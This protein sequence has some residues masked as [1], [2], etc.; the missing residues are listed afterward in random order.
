VEQVTVQKI[1]SLPKMDSFFSGGKADPYAVIEYQPHSQAGN[2]EK[3]T[4]QTEPRKNTLS[5]TWEEGFQFSPIRSSA[6]ELVI[7]FYDWDRLN[8]HEFIGNFVMPTQVLDRSSSMMELPT[9]NPNP[10][11]LT[12]N[13]QPSTLNPNPSRPYR[14]CQRLHPRPWNSGKM[15]RAT[16]AL[17]SNRSSWMSGERQSRVGVLHAGGLGRPFGLCFPTLRWDGTGFGRGCG[18]LYSS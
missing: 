9:G 11:P 4:K 10:Q 12:P 2:G 6:S 5:A 15:S 8:K 17:R 3:Q 7:T 18:L 16:A 1:E 13:P 14:C